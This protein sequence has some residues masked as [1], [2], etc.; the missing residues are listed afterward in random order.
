MTKVSRRDFLKLVRNGL[1]WTSAALGLGGLF[2]FLDYEPNPSPKTEFELGSAVE[3]S[4]R[5]ADN[6]GERSCYASPHR[7]R[8]L[9]FQFNLHPPGLQGGTDQGRVRLSLP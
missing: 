2:R 8:L 9:S 1:L 4:A 3:L 5:L 6:A 7:E